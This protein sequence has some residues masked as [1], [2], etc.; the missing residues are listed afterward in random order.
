MTEIQA[1]LVE[2]A[3][4]IDQISK[5]NH[6]RCYLDGKTLQAA[7]R[8][9]GY[10][11]E[12]P[13][14]ELLMPAKDAVSLMQILKEQGRADRYLESMMTNGAF[15]GVRL[16]YGSRNTLDF[17]TTQFGFYDHHGIQ[18]TIHIL[19]PAGKGEDSKMERLR[20]DM[21]CA[22]EAD[23]DPIHMAAPK[24]EPGSTAA[25]L[26]RGA[27][28]VLGKKAAARHLFRFALGAGRS[29]ENGWYLKPYWKNTREH[30]PAEWFG[31]GVAVDFEHH[32]FQAPAKTAEYL[33]RRIG[34]SWETSAPKYQP[35][36]PTSRLIDTEIPYAEYLEALQEESIDQNKIWKKWTAYRQKQKE[37]RGYSKLRKKAWYYLFLSGTRYALW[38]YYMPKKEY[39][40]QLYVAGVL[41]GL[42]RE[43]K[44]YADEAKE[45]IKLG[46]GLYFDK[47]LFRYLK[48]VMEHQGEGVLFEKIEKAVPKNHL[49][50]IVLKD[51]NGEPL[52]IE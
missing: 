50:P 20:T 39:L 44:L 37:F 21:E 48:I 22:W 28:K 46:L 42:K 5:E 32:S 9:Q 41:E 40:N 49:D 19:R 1:I 23:S 35:Y 16:H 24:V 34:K 11:N 18:V 8:C 12:I 27:K 25:K 47:D 33:R 31:E 13:E 26:V 7:M 29:E 45:Q 38:N 2:L 15:P 6:L 43:L 52:P 17:N 10:E 36:K 4:E 3:A 51:H 30:Y 14:L